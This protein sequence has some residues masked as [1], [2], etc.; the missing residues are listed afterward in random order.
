MFRF[1]AALTLAAC[2]IAPT[3]ASAQGPAPPALA[4]AAWTLVDVTSGQTIASHQTDER[5]D[6][7]SITK[8][9]T[10][11]LVFGALRQKAIVP[12][13]MVSVS[14]KAWRAEGSRMF[15]EPRKSVSVDELVHGMIVQSGND[16]S[17]ALAEPNVVGHRQLR[18]YPM[19]IKNQAQPFTNQ[20]FG[21]RTKN[22]LAPKPNLASGRADESRNAA[23]QGGLP[24]PVG[25]DY[26]NDLPPRDI[27]IET[28]QYRHAA[29][30]GVKVPY[31][32]HRAPP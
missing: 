10:A 14:E 31:L 11:Y 21:R 5:R 19:A 29:I 4:A 13:Q 16:A 2:A 3:L 23:Q 12:S 32:K 28:A 6:P 25:A 30:T 9:M 15:I 1:L 27:E 7:A 22:A 26:Q 20:R 8:L 17:I 18:K 24:C